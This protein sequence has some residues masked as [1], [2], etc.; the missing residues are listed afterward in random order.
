MHKL[1]PTQTHDAETKMRSKNEKSL[2]NV[3]F[4]VAYVSEKRVHRTSFLG[5]QLYCVVRTPM[6]YLDLRNHLEK[7]PQKLLVNCNLCTCVPDSH[8]RP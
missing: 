8:R 3:L 2:D 5:G 4:V 7:G 6:S 1:P